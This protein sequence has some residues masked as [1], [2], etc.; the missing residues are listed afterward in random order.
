[1][2]SVPLDRITAVVYLGDG[3][4]TGFIVTIALFRGPGFGEMLAKVDLNGEIADNSTFNVDLVFQVPVIYDTD[5]NG[6]TMYLDHK[7]GTGSGN[8]NTTGRITLEYFGQ[9]YPQNGG[10]WFR[11]Y[12]LLFDI[13]NN[14]V[15]R[16]VSITL[17]HPCESCPKGPPVSGGGGRLRDGKRKTA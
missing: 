11:T 6:S 5:I 16:D 15:N 2:A 10:E 3:I 7:N 4:D 14:H 17:L 13:G 1:M 8:D 12:Q 9:G